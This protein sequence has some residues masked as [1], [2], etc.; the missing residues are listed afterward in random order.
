MTISYATYVPSFY[1]SNTHAVI[2]WMK[3]SSFLLFIENCNI[4]ESNLSLQ[5]YMD[6]CTKRHHHIEPLFSLV[7]E[8]ALLHF[9]HLAPHLHSQYLFPFCRTKVGK[10][11]QKK[12]WWTNSKIKENKTLRYLSSCTNKI[13]IFRDKKRSIIFYY[14]K[15]WLGTGGTF[16]IGEE[17]KED[18]ANPPSFPI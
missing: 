17:E 6:T 2:L 15:F 9:Q 11:K 7:E 4:Y 1:T 3:L 14:P 8:G 10:K 16:S 13:I 5:L 18:D 12:T